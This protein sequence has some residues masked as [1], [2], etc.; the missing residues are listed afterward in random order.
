MNRDNTKERGY[1]LLYVI[2]AGSLFAALAASILISALRELEIS[3]QEMS[4]V[5]ARFAAESGVECISYW[6]ATNWPR[7]LDTTGPASTI[8]CNTLITNESFT[9]PGPSGDDECDEYSHTMQIGPFESANDQCADV[10]IEIEQHIATPLVCT[11]NV[12]V[13]GYSDCT[14]DPFTQRSVWYQI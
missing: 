5:K 4:A 9:S 10:I 14:T 1:V 8:H 13:H 3:E 7:P 6:Q 2:I 11:T 12:T